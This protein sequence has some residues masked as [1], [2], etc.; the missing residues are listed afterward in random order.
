MSG[1]NDDEAL[2]NDEIRKV[3]VKYRIPYSTKYV[4]L[5]NTEYRLYSKDSN[6]EIDV[7]EWDKIN[8]IGNVNYFTINTSGLISG[9]YFVDIKVKTKYEQR[10]FKNVLKFSKIN[11]ITK[12]NR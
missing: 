2:N 9:N 4:T 1:I 5:N 12:I 7:I 8:N 11:N 6:R 10:I 3:E